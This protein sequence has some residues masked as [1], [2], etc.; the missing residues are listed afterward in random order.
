MMHGPIERQG[1]VNFFDHKGLGIYV[2]RCNHY[3]CSHSV[4][5]EE[6]GTL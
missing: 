6:T 5:G 1:Y 4:C 2:L 3:V